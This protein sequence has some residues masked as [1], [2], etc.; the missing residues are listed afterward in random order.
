MIRQII[1]FRQQGESTAHLLRSANFLAES[2][3]SVASRT[4]S[5]A[6]PTATVG[7]GGWHA[8]DTAA[9]SGSSGEGATA[10]PIVGQPCG[11][12]WAGGWHARD[13][14][15]SSGSGGEGA[16]ASPGGG[17]SA[18]LRVRG[19]QGTVATITRGRRRSGVMMIIIKDRRRSGATV[20]WQ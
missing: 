13:T 7:L 8:R 3:W 18:E 9:S 19:C 12:G 15:A 1:E 16:T 5:W 4:Q 10:Y 14:A 6:S 2:L 20:E 17:G 11:D